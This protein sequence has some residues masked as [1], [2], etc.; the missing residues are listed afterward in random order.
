MPLLDTPARLPITDKIEPL[1]IGGKAVMGD[2]PVLDVINPADGSV[3]GRVA[4]STPAQVRQTVA[5]AG[6]A[7]R[8]TGWGGC[9]MNARGSCRARRTR[10]NVRPIIW[11]NCR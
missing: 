7:L 10:S 5:A 9:R 4:T 11:P 6:D 3:I 1:L 8:A 2:G